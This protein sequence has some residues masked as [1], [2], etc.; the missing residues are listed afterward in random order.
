MGKCERPVGP[1]LAFIAN[2]ALR[3]PVSDSREL[4]IRSFCS[5]AQVSKAVPFFSATI[6]LL[7]TRST[8]WSQFLCLLLFFSFSVFHSLPLDLY[9][10]DCLREP[11]KVF[12]PP[13]PSCPLPMPYFSFFF[14]E[15]NFFMVLCRFLLYNEVNQGNTCTPSL[16]IH[17]SPHPS[18]SSQSPEPGSLY[19]TAASH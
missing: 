18:G 16:L 14:F 2:A 1:F 8:P 15:D 3:A 10:E 12:L 4:S 17:I 7:D 11:S 13:S 5:S 19:Y 6:L 9:S